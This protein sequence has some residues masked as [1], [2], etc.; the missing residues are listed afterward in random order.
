M[1]SLGVVTKTDDRSR[2]DSPED[3]IAAAVEEAMSARSAA[4][5]AAAVDGG[6]FG[7]LGPAF[8]GEIH[9]FCF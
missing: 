7:P 5:A 9:D 6:G 2:W 8:H 4:A 3:P 1:K